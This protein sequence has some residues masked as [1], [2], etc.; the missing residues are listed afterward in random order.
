MK[1][2]NTQAILHY[3]QGLCS[4]F[5]FHKIFERM[6]NLGIIQSEDNYKNISITKKFGD[7]IK[8]RRIIH[9]SIE[10]NSRQ[11]LTINGNN[12]RAI[13]NPSNILR[14]IVFKSLLQF[15]PILTELRH[16]SQIYEIEKTMMCEYCSFACV[17]IY[18]L[19]EGEIPY[20]TKTCDYYEDD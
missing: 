3:M 15:I 14:S 19:F 17:M 13:T 20:I 7:L 1:K 18:L 9:Q 10:M 5:Q 11:I 16:R 2:V 4:N 12:I 6:A 8:D